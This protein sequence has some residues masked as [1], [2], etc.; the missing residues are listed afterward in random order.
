MIDLSGKNQK[1]WPDLSGKTVAILASGPSMTKEQCEVVR[2][3]GWY[4]IAINETWRLALWADMLYGC[5]WQWWRTCRPLQADFKGLRVLG[6]LPNTTKKRA[7]LPSEMKW[8]EPL[9]HYVPVRAGYSKMLLGGREIGAGSNSAFQAANIAV[10]C[11]VS[12][13]VLLGVDCHSPNKHW[14]GNHSHPEAPHQKKT[15]MKTWM[16][17]WELS[18]DQLAERKVEVVNCSLGS[19]LK[20]FPIRKV[21]TVL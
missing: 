2:D 19:A 20:V 7:H 16:K 3:R 6:S 14:H 9:L 10:R 11:N 15:L 17:A 4:A 8:Q 21:E 13:L 5:D 18:V 12:R 1:W